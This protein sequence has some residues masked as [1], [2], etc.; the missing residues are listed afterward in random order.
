LGKKLY[1]GNLAYDVTQEELQDVFS[2]A[3]TVTS[4]SVVADKFSGQ[5]RGFAFVEM[6]SDEEAKE[7]IS[8]LDGYSMKGRNLRVDEARPREPGRFP[9]G[10]GGQSGGGRKPRW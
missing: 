4:V 6:S 7:A 5:S 1:I 10:S 9:S 3:G 8:K 2:Q